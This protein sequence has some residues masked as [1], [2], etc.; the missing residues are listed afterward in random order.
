M[1]EEP[2]QNSLAKKRYSTPVVAR[3]LNAMVDAMLEELFQREVQW[4]GSKMQATPAV[5]RLQRAALR[6]GCGGSVRLPVRYT[7]RVGLHI[8]KGGGVCSVF[9]SPLLLFCLMYGSVLMSYRSSMPYEKNAPFAPL[10]CNAFVSVF[11]YR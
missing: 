7:A 2:R 3:L 8:G 6:L 4:S 9:L 5:E 10:G 11:P 1:V